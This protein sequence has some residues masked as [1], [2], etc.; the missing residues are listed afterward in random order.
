MDSGSKYN[1]IDKTSWE[2]MKTQLVKVNKMTKGSD[3]VFR[4]YGG[5]PLTIRGM[6]NAELTVGSKSVEELFYITEEKGQILVGLQTAT[7]MGILELKAELVQSLQTA[8]PFNKMKGIQIVLPINDQ[9][10]PVQQPYRRVPAPLEKAVEEKICQMLEMDIIEKVDGPACWI[11]PVVVVPKDD[12][13]VRLCIDMRRANKAIE[14]EK[15]PLPTILQYCHIC[16]KRSIFLN[17]I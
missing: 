12:G 14:R 1:L 7:K 11:S 4:S 8:K 17:W 5:T 16:G 3:R 13:Q 9:V 6:I 2:F 15:H 10:R